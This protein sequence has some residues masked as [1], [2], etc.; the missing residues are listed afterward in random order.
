MSEPV[1]AHIVRARRVAGL[2]LVLT[3]LA[4][5]GGMAYTGYWAATRPP[6]VGPLTA[7][8]GSG[9]GSGAAVGRLIETHAGR[10]VGKVTQSGSGT[11]TADIMLDGPAD[12]GDLAGF[13]KYPT[14]GCSGVLTLVRDDG[15]SADLQEDITADPSQRCA[16]PVNI[17]LE[18]LPDGTLRY[19]DT[20]E[21][22]QF[23]DGILSPSSGVPA[24]RSSGTA[25]TRP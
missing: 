21:G 24:R 20:D 2:L 6:V 9:P 1:P 25:R 14:L 5:I 23:F 12:V 15:Q 19:R 13:S 16:S 18:A 11:W 7:G 17:T 4:V 8:G 22:G 10:W 3:A